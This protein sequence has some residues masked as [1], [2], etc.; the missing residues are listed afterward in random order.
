[1]KSTVHGQSDEQLVVQ[2]R[3][4]DR[5]ALEAIYF[6][7]AD[8]LF[9]FALKRLDCKETAADMIQEL[10]LKLWTRR[11]A[12]SVQGNL[13]AY[14]TVCLRNMVID[15]YSH[16]QVKN[17]YHT[18]AARQEADNHTADLIN[19]NDTRHRLQT[20]MDSL[21][22][23]MK[24]IFYLN[25]MEDYSIDEIAD[26][27]NLSRQTVKNQ[28][29]AALLTWYF[30]E[31]EYH[32]LLKKHNQGACTEE[33]L[34]LLDEYLLSRN[35]PSADP[36]VEDTLL[37]GTF[38]RISD[39]IDADEKQ[40]T[41]RRL[42]TSM[43]VRIA[44]SLIL[45]FAVG[46]LLY[47]QKDVVNNY[48]DPERFTNISSPKGKHMTVNL[49]DGSVVL[50][51]Q[52]SRLSYSNRFNDTLREVSLTGEAYFQVTPNKA[53]PFIVHTGHLDTRVLG[54]SFNIEAYPFSS[55]IAVELITG[56]IWLTANK[57]GTQNVNDILTPNQTAEYDTASGQT[58]KGE[59]ANA[60]NYI[61]WKDDK[62]RF[63]NT[64][65]DEVVRR[66]NVNFRS[67]I[68][69][70][71]KALATQSIYGD[72]SLTTQP[73][74]IV[75]TI[76]ILI[77]ARYYIKQDGSIMLYQATGNPQTI[78]MVY[79]ATGR[80]QSIIERPVTV[81]INARPLSDV[82][83]II[84]QQTH[85]DFLYTAAIKL[86]RV[87]NLKASNEPLKVVLYKLLNPLGLQYKVANDQ[88][89]ILKKEEQGNVDQ[90]VTGQV[91]DEKGL[92]MPNVTIRVKGTNLATVSNNDGYYTIKIPGMDAILEYNYIGYETQFVTVAGQTSINIKMVPNAQ[93]MNEVVITALNIK[94]DSRSLGY[95]VNK[96]DGSSVNTVQTPN[97][98]NAL[99]GKVPGVNVS[100]IGNGVAG[101]K[102]IVI[103]GA[104][105]LTGNNQPLWVVDGIIINT[106]TLGGPDATG[107]YDYGDGLT[108]INPDD[109][110]SISVLKGNAAAALYG[111]RASNGVIL[112]TTKSGK[113]TKGKQQVDFSTSEM[114]D[115]LVNPTDFQYVYGQT[116]AA[117]LTSLPTSAAQAYTSDSWGHKLDGSPAVQFDGVTRPFSPV[118]DNYE[119]F[120]K[121]GSTLTNTVALAGSNNNTDYR[122]SLSNLT[123]NDIIPNSGFNRTGLNSKLHS[124][125]GQLG[126][127]VILDYTYQKANNRPYTGGN[128]SN[129]FYSLLYLPGNINIDNLKPGYKADGTE[130]QFAD[131]ISNPWYFVNKEKETDVRNTLTGAI[132]LH[133]QFTKWLY[134][135]ARMTRDNYW[136]QR[137][138]YVPN[139]NTSTSTPGGSFDQ[140]TLNN[141]ENNYEGIVGINPALIGR[142]SISAYGGGNI[143]WRATGNVI[144]SGTTFA[145][146]GVYT[147]NNLV[148]KTPS[149]SLV[150]Q[151]TNSLF[152]SVDMAYNRFLYLTLT[153]R[154]D[155]FST[156][157][158]QQNSLFY[159]SAALGFVFSDAF[160]M[161]HWLSYGKLRAS[162]AQV[163]GDAGPGQLALSYSLTSAAYGS[164][165][166]QYIGTSNIPNQNLKPLL[167]TDYEYGLEMDVLGN[168]LGFNIDYYKRSIKNDIVTSSVPASTG[169]ATAILNI[170]RMRNEGIELEVHATP[171]KTKSF[172]WNISGTFS[173]NNSKVVQLGVG[174]KGPNIVLASS[175]SGNGT[176]QLEEGLPYDGIYGYTYLRDAKG[177]KEYDVNGLPLYNST[178][179]RL[180]NGDYNKLV[181]LGNTFLYKNFSF[182]FLVDSK[183]G[184]DIYSETNATAYDNGKSK[185]TLP[186][187]ETGIVGPG[188]NQ[189]GTTNT[190]LVPAVNISNYYKQIKQIT[191]QFVY[192]ASFAKLREVALTY[193]LPSPF[194]T[195]LHISNASVAFVAR[196]LFILYKDKNLH[197]VDPES[198]VM[199]GNAQG[200]ERMEYPPTRNYGIT[201]R[202]SF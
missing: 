132:S 68:V 133:Y 202:L 86:D 142:F 67:H 165:T 100:N 123:N 196:N 173:N 102:R 11:N 77:K 98:I 195:R 170:G 80:S 90:R 97:I 99:A 199:S 53:K 35:E 27:F 134:A 45:V 186:G 36:F 25:K 10:F 55:R 57:S 147:F 16:E 178:Q 107:G 182:Y 56:K 33:E 138:Q 44:A 131:G 74:D 120:F 103:R 171:V 146:P 112:I 139:G 193:H 116:S 174:A 152:A 160:K 93:N 88:V 81:D 167:S 92:S 111:S 4:G 198:N 66:L 154:D 82:I 121:T 71:D 172:T 75:K 200:I 110:E 72:F 181:G 19:Y 51:N 76:C 95:T 48:L 32:H 114:I 137:L 30:D 143:N 23:K 6:R 141:I 188:D 96:L 5:G 54:T 83:N 149:T 162:A 163:S 41:K 128:T 187:R 64:R 175:K 190:V 176:I 38:E 31:Q 157:P 52:E 49:P 150:N 7:Y 192:N 101:T 69:L 89:L 115:K 126:V 42:I 91:T 177:N 179:T 194:L 117:S 136:V 127:D 118:T 124:K 85:V 50:L 87:V 185:E 161:P 201:L 59:V 61:A 159:P 183:F 130:L 63:S 65:L 13:Q 79:P 105:S 78:N 43:P 8:F 37:T 158:L 151:K 1:M 169:Y 135:R 122:V 73:I 40:R 166:L 26:K 22:G 148:T 197:N 113:T 3:A 109:I 168:R 125:F 17:K 14:L 119:R 104:S 29:G 153:G 34:L 39:K 144:N 108:G 94:K 156:L 70:A 58:K 145:V 129:I 15:H 184:A 21:P 9:R 20:G 155:W 140:R 189:S 191:E 24:Q 18:I 60:E 28:L 12:L 164:N 47:H 84:T 62:V 106:A 2:L 180:G 46:V